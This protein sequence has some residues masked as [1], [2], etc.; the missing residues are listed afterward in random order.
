MGDGFRDD[1][2]LG[3]GLGEWGRDGAGVV[4][5][6]EAVAESG[7]AEEFA[8]AAAVAT[9]WLGLLWWC[10]GGHGCEW[11]ALYG[12]VRDGDG[13]V[14]ARARGWARLGRGWSGLA[15]AVMMRVLRGLAGGGWRREPGASDVFNGCCWV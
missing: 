6:D 12:W 2:S 7:E 5:G 9:L 10:I 14:D 13:A 3:L 8:D 4:E 1:G 15:G 11:F